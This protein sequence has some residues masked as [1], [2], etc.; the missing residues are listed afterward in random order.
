[1]ADEANPSAQELTSVVLFLCQ[2]F[3]KRWNEYGMFCLKMKFYA[4]EN[5]GCPVEMI[6]C[7]GE[8]KEFPQ[9]MIDY[10]L[11]RSSILTMEVIKFFVVE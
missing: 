3:G 7:R 1:M 10:T 4:T 5:G 2:D 9:E 11:L 8:N 6:L